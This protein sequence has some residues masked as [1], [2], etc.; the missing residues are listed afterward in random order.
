MT[1][2]VTTTTIPIQV[3]DTTEWYMVEFQGV[4]GTPTTL[5]GRVAAT[6]KME[7]GAPFMVCG[8]LRVKGEEKKLAK[9]L[10]VLRKDKSDPNAI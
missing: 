10:L 8:P 6:I 1:S 5:E 2:P 4:F 7:G 9:P 3:G